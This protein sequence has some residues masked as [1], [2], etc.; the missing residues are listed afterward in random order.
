VKFPNF[1]VRSLVVII[2]QIHLAN[3]G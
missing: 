2:M 1:L 3:K